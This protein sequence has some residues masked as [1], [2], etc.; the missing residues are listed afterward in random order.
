MST[1][2]GNRD[3]NEWMN[4]PV[5]PGAIT[6]VFN[7]GG[8]PPEIKSVNRI[9]KNRGIPWES[10]VGQK[11]GPFLYKSYK[12]PFIIIKEMNLVILVVPFF[13]FF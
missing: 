9:F 4:G 3:M 6:T 5:R 1:N 13:F 10:L 12:T 11:G 8:L 2:G 7:E